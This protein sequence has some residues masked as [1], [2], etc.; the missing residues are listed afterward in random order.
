MGVDN[1]RVI[2]MEC[3][4]NGEIRKNRPCELFPATTI[5]I[6]DID[7]ILEGINNEKSIK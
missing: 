2:T 1:H 3:A 7:I 6:T 4:K 5:F